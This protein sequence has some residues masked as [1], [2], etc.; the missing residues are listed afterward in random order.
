[1]STTTL[2]EFWNE[3]N[4]TSVFVSG[5][6]CPSGQTLIQNLED[7][8]ED[9]CNLHEV[10]DNGLFG[11]DWDNDGAPVEESP[12]WKA[13]GEVSAD[14]KEWRWNGLGGLTDNRGN[15]YHQVVLF[16]E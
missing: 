16:C 15:D 3:N 12:A 7:E 13:V 10:I 1:M 5:N 8:G 11:G 14:G 6:G 9:Y 2:R 4:V